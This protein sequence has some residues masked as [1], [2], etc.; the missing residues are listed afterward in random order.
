MGFFDVLGLAREQLQIIYVVIARITI[1]M[2]HDLFR[3]Q[4]APK[5]LFHDVS[6]FK[7]VFRPR[8]FDIGGMGV[9]IGNDHQDI[10]IVPYLSA[11]VPSRRLLLSLSV[12][13]IVFTLH[14]LTIHRII[15]AAY[16]AVVGGVCISQVQECAGATLGA[17]ASVRATGKLPERLAALLARHPLALLF[18]VT[19]ATMGTILGF[20]RRIRFVLFST[21]LTLS[22]NHRLNCTVLW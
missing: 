7:Q 16:I 15:L 2:M 10:A 17:K 5:M 22:G 9:A 20:Y 3:F 14:A 13:G 12:H 1:N 19:G 21:V 4:I 6:V 18:G 8:R 11:A